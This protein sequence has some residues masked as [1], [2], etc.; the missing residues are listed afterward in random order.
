MKTDKQGHSKIWLGSALAALVASVAV[1][2]VMLQMERQMLSDYE[3]GV[4]YVAAQAIPKGVTLTE[5]NVGDYIKQVEMDVQLIPAKALQ[6]EEHICGMIAGGNLDAGAVLTEGMFEKQDEI[7]A[8]MAEPVIA[9]FKAEDLYQ[10]VGG[11]LRP[12]DRIHIY[13]VTDTGIAGLI[14]QNVF[15]EKVFDSGGNSI[16]AGNEGAC[17]Q[18][19]NIYLDA[20][21]VERFYT[22]LAGGT[23]RVVKVCD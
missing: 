4:V 10:V 16:D 23:L 22:E 1:F 8:N 12:G 17:A 5:Q 11:V 20:T 6:S 13:T 3:R 14:W 19:I 18:R 21:D 15:V 2:V 9:G 7:T